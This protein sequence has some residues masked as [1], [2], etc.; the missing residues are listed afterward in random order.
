MLFTEIITVIMRIVKS[1]QI[2]C[3]KDAA[4]LTVKADNTY[5]YHCASKGSRNKLTERTNYNQFLAP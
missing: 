1:T 4:Y 3:G 5:T 2:H